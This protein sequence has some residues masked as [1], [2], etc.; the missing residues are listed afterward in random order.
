[1]SKFISNRLEV[2]KRA[3]ENL[4]NEK[5][6]SNDQYTHIKQRSEL[7]FELRKGR[8]TASEI[9]S[10]MGISPYISRNKIFHKKKYDDE[11]N[12]SA[13]Q[14]KIMQ[15]GTDMEPKAFSRTCR[16]FSDDDQ[17]EIRETG[18]WIDKDRPIGASPDGL[19]Y[20]HNHLISVVEIKCPWRKRIYE[21][22]FEETPT[23]PN[24][25]YIQIQVQM[26]VTNTFSAIYVCYID[27][28]NFAVVQ[29]ARNNDCIKLI[30]EH[31]TSFDH[32]VKYKNSI[33]MM[34]RGEKRNLNEKIKNMQNLPM[35]MEILHK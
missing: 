27:D 28:D 8:Y 31:I 2:N 6:T 11:Y 26:Y 12:I 16:F 20:Y 33:P 32:F 24:H 34:Q 29:I 35:S 21:S 25:H 3:V 17:V 4:K 30:L 15:Y 5:I 14:K 1:M 13:Y 9:G 23:I 7:W 10:I 18:L 19:F 22:L